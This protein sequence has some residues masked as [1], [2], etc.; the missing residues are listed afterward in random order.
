MACACNRKKASTAKYVV[1]HADG[2]EKS[3][4]SE[5]EAKMAVAR[6]GGTY[7]KG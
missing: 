7:K 5:V 6:R 2:S 1:K 3:Y 4:R